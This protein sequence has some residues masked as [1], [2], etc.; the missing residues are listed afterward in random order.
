MA[1][2][3]LETDY[4][5]EDNNIKPVANSTDSYNR[6]PFHVI[7]ILIYILFSLI[8]RIWFWNMIKIL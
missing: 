1:C 8:I 3:L 4:T 6:T 2:N 7:Y 5:W